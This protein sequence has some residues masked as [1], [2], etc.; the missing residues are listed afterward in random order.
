MQPLTSARN[1]I[2][3]SRDK[4]EEMKCASSLDDLEECWKQ[5]LHRIERTWNK[6]KHQL[7]AS[8]KFQGWTRRGAIEKLRSNDP[9]L[10]YLKNARGADEHTINDITGRQS[11][12]I[13][14]NTANNDGYIGYLEL[15]TKDG[16]VD[17][18]TD[19]PLDI[20]FIPEKTILV[21]VL[22][23]GK[24]FKVPTTHLDEKLNHIDPVSIADE[25]VRFY[26]RFLD[27]AEKYFCKTKPSHS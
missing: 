8:P 20:I 23:R 13:G 7:Q 5:Y 17:I 16:Q 9:L 19:T 21:D 14:I 1:E 6:A 24:I 10:S 4:I 12:R 26:E 25:G 3:K 22:N 27:E 18:K 2:Q 11:G 15:S